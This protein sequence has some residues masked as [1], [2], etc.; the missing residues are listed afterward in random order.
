[1]SGRIELR[2]PGGTTLAARRVPARRADLPGIVFCGG[3]RSDMTG[4]KARRLEAFCAGRGQGY[5]RFDYR[6]H[7]ESGGAFADGTI[8]GWR[9]D[10]LAVLD[11]ATEGPQ[12]LVGSSMGGWLALLAAL[13]R[14]ERVAGLVTVA[15][16]VDM[17]ED[18]VWGRL[19]DDARAALR[20]D[21]VLH[22]PST[23]DAE[24]YP[25]TW[26]LVEEG[27]R[28]LLLG[29]AVG[30]D[31]PAR[32]LHGMADPD[33]PWRQSLRLAEALTGSDVRLILVKDG[34]HRLSRPADLALLEAAVAELSDG[35]RSSA[36][37]DA[38]GTPP[39]G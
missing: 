14:P 2:G 11:Q 18:L 39:P 25:F 13:A 30:F 19:D 38:P 35:A 36:S 9:D 28:H 37:A 22:A 20:R 6:G 1:M 24:P 32:L 10:V 34:D 15:A 5:V 8:G 31:R 29:G 17:T 3:Y 7:G 26:R 21:G 27:R 12:V 16:A 4:I 33:V 23:Y